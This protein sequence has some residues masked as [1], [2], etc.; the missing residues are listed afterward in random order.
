MQRQDPAKCKCNRFFSRKRIGRYS[1]SSEMAQSALCELACLTRVL[2][3]SFF[4]SLRRHP[5]N[6]RQER[7]FLNTFEATCEDSVDVEVSL[8]VLP[9]SSPPSQSNDQECDSREHE[10]QTEPYEC[11]ER[12]FGGFRDENSRAKLFVHEGNPNI[13]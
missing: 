4:P 3:V 11:E 10:Q 6:V 1:V 12:C 5:P 13:C 9:V 2:M 8:Y 7:R